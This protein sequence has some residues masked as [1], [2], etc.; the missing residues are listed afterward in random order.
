MA[1][2]EATI[3]GIYTEINQRKAEVGELSFVEFYDDEYKSLLHRVK[4]IIRFYDHYSFRNHKK[5][6]RMIFLAFACEYVRRE[7]IIDDN[8]FWD[9]FQAT[10]GIGS[11]Y[12]NQMR[13]M[14]WKGYEEEDIPQQEG[15]WNRL[16]VR[17]LIDK[18]SEARETNKSIRE[19]FS[20]F[21]LWYYQNHQNGAEVTHKLI[22]RYKIKTE[23]NLPITDK[24]IPALNRECQIL[25]KV[26]EYAIE[27]GLYLSTSDL[28]TY[29][30][31]IIA[32]L[33]EEYDPTHLCLIHDERSLRNL[34]T[35]LENQRTPIQFLK[36]LEN[37]ASATVTSPNGK[38]IPAYK[39][40]KLWHAQSLEYGLYQLDEAKY[41]VVPLCWLRLEEIASWPYEKIISLKREGYIGYKKRKPFKVKIGEE[42]HDGKVCSFQ[43][44]D[45]AYVWAGVIRKA[46]HLIIDKHHCHQSGLD[47]KSTLRMGY[48]EEG[49]PTIVICI[50]KL[51]A[52]FPDHPGECLIIQTLQ[53]F[54]QIEHLRSNG[55]INFHQ[56]IIIALEEFMNPGDISVDVSISLGEELLDRKSFTLEP[57]YLFSTRN[58]EKISHSSE[59]LQ[60]EDR[61]YLFSSLKNSPQCIDGTKIELLDVTFGPYKIYEVT[62]KDKNNLLF[63]TVGNLSW[64][65]QHQNYFSVQIDPQAQ[66]DIVCLARH[67]IYSFG[68]ANIRVSTGMHLFDNS[69]KC[70]VFYSS[71]LIDE[72]PLAECLQ[73]DGNNSYVFS[74]KFLINLDKK[75]NHRYGRYDVLFLVGNRLITQIT[76]ALIPRISSLPSFIETLYSENKPFELN[77]PSTDLSV[78]NPTTETIESSATLSLNPKL[79]TQIWTKEIKEIVQLT[80]EEIIT[81]LMFPT[82][83]ETIQICFRPKVFG[84]RLYQKSNLIDQQNN[85]HAIHYQQVNEFDFYALG[86]SALYVVSGPYYEVKLYIGKKQVWS[87]RADD[88]GRLSIEDLSFLKPYCKREKIVVKVVSEN[89]E[90]TIF[91]WWKPLLDEISVQEGKIHLYMSGPAGASVILHLVDLGGNILFEQEIPCEG[92]HLNVSVN[93]LPIGTIDGPYYLFPIYHCPSGQKILASRQWRISR[94]IEIPESWLK[95]GLGVDSDSLPLLSILCS[96][97]N[98]PE[99]SMP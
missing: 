83:N 18:I 56:T 75:S 49:N 52:Y 21:F 95:A 77:I 25:A 61:F 1:F 90:K 99:I 5:K 79:A 48:N 64:E 66:T 45:K 59:Y 37:Q 70:Q 22:L 13:E 4:E 42:I 72:S 24:R 60:N 88:Q 87:D 78:W 65:I 14:L 31:K 63:F 34:I 97:M 29:R 40:H 76:L 94:S 28:C 6:A 9:G 68:Q 85:R 41:R 17:S 26:I 96:D 16:V 84:I 11:V 55:S 81:S 19:H 89:L 38:Q 10:L 74:S 15:N 33:G 43:P 71:E 27:N 51:K 36:E 92:E 30:Q 98:N 93:M 57:A 69:M 58:H 8:V 39:A 20:K 7:K 73:S 80:A 3:E 62:W 23:I 86:T 67:Q 32:A 35:E 2:R 46:E 54:K 47:W 82:I 44:D 50:D 53:G 12:E 91:I